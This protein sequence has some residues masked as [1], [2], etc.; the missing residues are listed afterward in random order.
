MTKTSGFESISTKRRWIA[1]LA[2]EAPEMVF[3]TLCHHMDLEWMYEAYRRTRKDGAVGVDGQ[4]AQAYAENLEFNLRSLLECAKSGSYQ[5]PPVRR[6][7]IAKGEGSQTRPIGIPTF[8]DKVLQRAVV[9]LLEP[10]YEQDFLDCSYGF[11]PGRSAHQAILSLRRRIMSM[12]GGWVLEV[13]IRKFFDTLDHR[14][15]REILRQRVRD[16]VV[17]RLIGKWLKAGV[18]ESGSLSYSKAGT[19]Q[20]G[21][22]SPLL[23][24][25]YLHEVLDSWFESMIIPRL[26]G[27]A[28]LV[29]YADDAVMVFTD[30]SDV[31]R[32]FAV[33]P[34]RFGKY[35]LSLHPD[36]TRFVRFHRPWLTATKADLRR[37]GPGTFDFLGFTHLWVRTLKGR[38]GVSSKTAKD[39]FRRALRSVKRWCREHRHLKAR[40]QWAMLTRK[41]Q[42]HYAYYG[43]TGNTRRI[44]QF[45]Y[46]VERVWRKW[47]SRRSNRAHIPWDR[48]DLLREH[49]PLPAARI[50]FHFSRCVAN[51]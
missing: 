12:R 38:W 20:G 23:A 22:A 26:K 5:A 25:V 11:R 10:I 6:V 24:S 16:G 13:D 35:G 41:L 4:S 49:Y 44:Q 51:A 48:F 37:C 2:K 7:H 40:E 18:L 34:K 8:E 17:E 42:G 29:R 1:Q 36:K 21:V 32:V 28:C 19:P 31:R 33:L 39:R 50:T 9:M 30:E 3:T 45:R 27:R 46:E 43:I 15:L 47:L 14:R